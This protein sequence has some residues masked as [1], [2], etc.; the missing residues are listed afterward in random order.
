MKE[1]YRSLSE[2]AAS[3]LRSMILNEK[4]YKP[5]DKLPN[6]RDLAEQMGVSRTS[7][8]EAIKL[9]VA[10]GF[11]TVRRGV[12]TFVN[13]N[14]GVISDPFGF[15]GLKNKKKLLLDWYNVRMVLEG[16]AMKM[17]TKNATNKEIEDIVQ[18]S[19]SGNKL[20][21]SN[22]P[23]FIRA[24]QQFHTSLIMAT[25]NEVMMKII[26]PLHEW[27]Y[28]TYY[29]ILFLKYEQYYKRAK[30]NALENHERISEFIMKRDGDG[31]NLAMRYHMLD[32]I[33]LI[34]DL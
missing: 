31:A 18:L 20:I 2:K 10:S 17:V 32:A 6:E 19:N 33:K 28:F 4:I 27:T 25:H 23:T 3:Q 30:K 7:I 5:N 24:D 16:E 8:R 15:E 13:D 12:G 9:L 22:D 11:L 26:P 21:L 29:E 1:T 34:E 14:P